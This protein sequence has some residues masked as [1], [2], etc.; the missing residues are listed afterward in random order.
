MLKR[1]AKVILQRPFTREE[2]AESIEKHLIKPPMPDDWYR[3]AQLVR[4]R[5]GTNLADGWRETLIM[6]E[7]KYFTDRPTW[8]T[9]RQALIE[10]MLDH[11]ILFL[12]FKVVR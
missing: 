9:Q 1:F 2:V 8:G 5:D 6:D 7:I 11:K 3:V 10:L 4:S 12:A